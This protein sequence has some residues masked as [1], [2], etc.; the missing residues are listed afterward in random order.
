MIQFYAPEAALTGVLGESD[1]RHAVKV[2]RLGCGSEINVVD[3]RG[4][5]YHCRLVNDDPRRAGIE[6][7]SVARRPKQWLGEIAILVAPAK[8]MD[9]MEWLVEKLTEVGVD[10]IIPV[11][12]Q[13]SERKEIKRERLEKIAISAMKQSL[14]AW[15]PEL[16]EM[17]PLKHA[18]E[19]V[20]GFDKY[21]GYCD[22]TIGLADFSTGYKQASRSAILIGPEGDFTPEEIKMLTTAGWE[23][24]TFGPTRLRTET[25]ALY[26]AIACH[27]LDSLTK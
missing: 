21:V 1:S 6:V 15:L 8:H 23:P 5:E 13:R 12:C 25:A 16:A 10:R 27:V 19:Q 18:V 3:G 11:R 4:N 7:V 22:E 9:R 14:K 20:H 2:L 17:M 26:G 24:V